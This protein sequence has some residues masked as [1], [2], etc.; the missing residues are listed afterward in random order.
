MKCELW[1]RCVPLWFLPQLYGPVTNIHD[2]SKVD[3]CR[4]KC[5]QIWLGQSI[6]DPRRQKTM[7]QIKWPSETSCRWGVLEM[8]R[9]RPQLRRTTSLQI[10]TRTYWPRY[11]RWPTDVAKYIYLLDC[12][13][14]ITMSA[15]TKRLSKHT[16]W[17]AI[18]NLVNLFIFKFQNVFI[19]AETINGLLLKCSDEV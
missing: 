5:L 7:A 19:F 14:L 11:P 18:L 4:R 12:L 2:F 13:K 15:R 17:L 1:I 6:L 8:P 9:W 10:C 16:C 3:R